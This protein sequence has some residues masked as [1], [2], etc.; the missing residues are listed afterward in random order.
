MVA[1]QLWTMAGCILCSLREQTTEP[2]DSSAWQGPPEVCSPTLCSQKGSLVTRPGCSGLSS[3]RILERLYKNK[4]KMVL[5]FF[6]SVV[7]WINARAPSRP[8]EYYAQVKPCYNIPYHTI[9]YNTIPYYT[10]TYVNNTH[11]NLVIHRNCI[12]TVDVSKSLFI[13]TPKVLIS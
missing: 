8:R 10:M 3:Q 4:L 7:Q 9:P 13:V 2:Q 5:G 12:R 6:L 11:I 1:L